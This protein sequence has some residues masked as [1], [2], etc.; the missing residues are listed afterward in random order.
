MPEYCNILKCFAALLNELRRASMGRGPLVEK[1]W[2]NAWCIARQADGNGE[3]VKH[4]HNCTKVLSQ[5][6]TPY[7]TN[8]RQYSKRRKEGGAH[9]NAQTP[10]L[11]FSLTTSEPEKCV[12]L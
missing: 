2:F 10:S 5:F 8:L 9:D 12:G 7:C 1:R 3:T 6:R 4:Y 11:Q